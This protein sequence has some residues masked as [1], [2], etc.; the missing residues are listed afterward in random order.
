MYLYYSRTTKLFRWAIKYKI[1]DYIMNNLKNIEKDM[2]T[3]QK[4]FITK[5][6]TMDVE[7]NALNYLNLLQNLLNKHNIKITLDF[8][9]AVPHKEEP[10]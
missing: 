9:G 8:T 10:T 2:N 5:I 7:K 3:I 1:L 6:I 4:M